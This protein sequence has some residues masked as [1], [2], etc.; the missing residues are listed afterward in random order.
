MDDDADIAD[1]DDDD[2]DDDDAG[3]MTIVLRT[4]VTAN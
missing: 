2:D 4:F 3:A 1:D